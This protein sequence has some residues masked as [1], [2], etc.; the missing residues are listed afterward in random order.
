M[1]HT[2]TPDTTTIYSP[3]CLLHG[4]EMP[5]PTS[6]N[7]KAKISKE[8][9]NHSQRLENLKASLKSAYKIVIG[10]NSQSHQTNK[11]YYDRKAKFRKFEVNDL[12]YLYNPAIKP[13]LSKKFLKKWTG[14]YKVVTRLSEIKLRDSGL[15][16]EKI[17]HVN[18]LKPYYDPQTWKPEMKQKSTKKLP[19]KPSSCQEEEKEDEHY[20][21]RFPLRTETQLQSRTLPDQTPITP[22]P[23]FQPTYISMS[24]NTDPNYEPSPKLPHLGENYSIHAQSILLQDYVLRIFYK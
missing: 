10:A 13:G 24:Q 7:L 2:A 11:E 15:T 21:G 18:R 8:N 19:K 3:F 14:P 16:K 23:D 9:V 4:R 22:D 12:V 20:L 6:E 5:V 17:V 1:A